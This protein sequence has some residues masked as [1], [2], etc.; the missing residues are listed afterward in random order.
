MRRRGASERP[1]HRNLGLRGAGLLVALVASVLLAGCTAASP[2]KADST[3]SSSTLVTT[4]GG[5]VTVGIDQA[6]TGCNPNAVG[7]D[8]WANQLVLAP[9]LPSAFVVQP[10]GHSTLDQA[11]VQ[12]AELVSTSPQ[13]IQ[14]KINPKA[15]W[16]DG[17]PI[18]AQDF[19]Y[20]WQEQ[21]GGG[22]TGS[23][24][25]A[26]PTQAASTLG[27]RDI[28]SVKG[29][30]DGKSVTVQFKSP[31]ADWQHLFH[32]LLPAH[33]MDKVGWNPSCST[34]SPQIDLSAGPFEIASVHP[35][36]QV[37]LVRNPKWW[38]TAPYLD[39]LIIRTATGSAQLARWLA[40]GEA[41]AIEPASFSPSF[42]EAVGSLGGAKSKLQLSTTMVDLQF[43]TTAP[44]LANRQ[45][46]TAVAKVINRDALVHAAASWADKAIVPAKSHLYAQSQKGY[47][48]LPAGVT[49]PFPTGSDLRSSDRLLVAAGYHRNHK[50]VWQDPRGRDL[51]ERMVVDDA[52]RF[53]RQ[54]ASII[55][56]QLRRDGIVVKVSGTSTA[57]SAGLALAHGNADMAVVAVHSSTYP[58]QALSWY[59]LSLGQPGVNGSQDWS[60]LDNPQVTKSL[61]TAA[62]ELNPNSA[63][64]LYQK[65][66]G[67]LWAVLPDLPLFTEPEVLAWSDRLGG[68]GPN[69]YGDGL[70]YYAQSWGLLVPA[71]EA[72]S[73]TTTSG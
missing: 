11:V 10:N 30:N 72:S 17:A 31:F 71:S 68:V 43:A 48:D 9:V 4:Q 20:A 26:A 3:T 50:G 51:V 45:L 47:P 22:G 5:T 41:Q 15:E 39:K 73:T 70:L 25:S 65:A 57:R 36:H 1:Q 32:N 69:T 27:Y 44:T 19:I 54:S 66:D 12:Q 52:D 14:Y 6:P 24:A 28:A 62:Q 34:V 2:A 16:S 42:L 53:A 37:V 13:I 61:T 64:P 23:A 8:T 21:R 67:T 58:T 29:S 18:T 56:Y 60:R 59:T 33:V 40:T 49:A 7:Q 55:A 38:G 46:R 63:R 35:G